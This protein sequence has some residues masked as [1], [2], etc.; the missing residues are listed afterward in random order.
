ML[1]S[2]IAYSS[3]NPSERYHRITGIFLAVC[4]LGDCERKQSLDEL[5]AEYPELRPEV[6]LL[7]TFHDQLAAASGRKRSASD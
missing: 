1:G 5:C 4:N 3:M 7:L 2:I 6:E